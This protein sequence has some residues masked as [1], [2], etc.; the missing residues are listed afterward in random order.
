[1]NP[2]EILLVEDNPTN[3]LVASQFLNK[4]N[5]NLEIASNGAEAIEMI[6][7]KKDYDV[8][9]MDLQ[10]PEMDGLETTKK[11]KKE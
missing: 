10:M 9:L 3:Q 7:H 4:W 1:M 8:I 2:I 6:A 11:I 5:V